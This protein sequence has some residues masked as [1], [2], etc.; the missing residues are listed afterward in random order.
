MT[1]TETYEVGRVLY[2]G[3]PGLHGLLS[4]MIEDDGFVVTMLGEP[5]QE[6]RGGGIPEAVAVG[7]LVTVSW[8]V[9]KAVGGQELLD[10]LGAVARRFRERGSGAE[11]SVKAPD[12]ILSKRE[13]SDAKKP[14]RH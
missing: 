5:P 8:E 14:G 11:A 9:A 6:R 13:D 1:E 2:R 12:T 10:R 3:V 7:F 4:Q